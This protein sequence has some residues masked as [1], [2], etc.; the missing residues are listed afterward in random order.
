MHL[1][2]D[3]AQ[4]TCRKGLTGEELAPETCEFSSVKK[5]VVVP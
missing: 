3:I 5:E 1:R 4:V 2:K